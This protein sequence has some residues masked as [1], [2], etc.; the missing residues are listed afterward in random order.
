[1]A[2]R[3]PEATPRR[4]GAGQRNPDQWH[5]H[6]SSSPVTCCSQAAAR[7]QDREDVRNA[8]TLLLAGDGDGGWPLGSQR[9][10]QVGGSLIGRPPECRAEQ[11]GRRR[12]GDG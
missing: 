6:G 3:S 5:V 12:V 4:P 2:R 7:L 8:T 1:M 11:I 10:E 9:Y